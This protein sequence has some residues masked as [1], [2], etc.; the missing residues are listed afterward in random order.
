M[1]RP[2]FI[3][4]FSSQCL[5][6]VMIV[7]NRQTKRLELVIRW[8]QTE[9]SYHSIHN[10][11]SGETILDLDGGGLLIGDDKIV[12]YGD[13][14]SSESKLVMRDFKPYFKSATVFCNRTNPLIPK[15]FKKWLDFQ[16][17]AISH[18]VWKLKHLL[19]W[20]GRKPKPWQLEYGYLFGWDKLDTEE[21]VLDW[22]SKS[23]SPPFLDA[24][25]TLKELLGSD[26]LKEED[27]LTVEGLIKPV[28]YRLGL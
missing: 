15:I 25:D 16:L 6:N 10:I 12:N 17:C 26:V 23:Y 21:L 19:H 1:K 20:T 11:F 13:F 5:T 9:E 24:F 18:G 22:E 28:I 14:V 27:K 8:N 7:R 3:G 4:I 2:L